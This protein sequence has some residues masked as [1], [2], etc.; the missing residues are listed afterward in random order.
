MAKT[1]LALARSVSS[2][3]ETV[4]ENGRRGASSN[5]KLIGEITFQGKS[6]ATMNVESALREHKTIE[7]LDRIQRKEVPP[8]RW[9]SN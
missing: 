9:L 3:A 8:P 6:I 1:N 4:E 2:L 7:M 5:D